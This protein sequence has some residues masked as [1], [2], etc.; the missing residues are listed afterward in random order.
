MFKSMKIGTRLGIGFLSIL[1]CASA[2]TYV[3]INRMGFL[4]EKTVS[5]YEHPYTTSNAISRVQLHIVKINRA[6]KDVLLAHNSGQ[7][8][9]KSQEISHLEKELY[10][11]H[12]ILK[13]SFLGDKAMLDKTYALIADWKKVRE[14]Q[15]ALALAGKKDEAEI[16]HRTKASLLVKDLEAVTEAIDDFADKKALSFMQNA[17]E[18]RKSAV[19]TV[20]SLLFFSI[21][22]SLVALLFLI[23]SVTI[24]LQAAV[25]ALKRVASGDLTANISDTEMRGDELGALMHAQ[26]TM[27]LSLAAIMRNLMDYA[28]KLSSSATEIGAATEEMSRG[29]DSQMNQVI[30]TSSGM[31]EMSASV[32]E[33][34]RNAKNTSETAV[35]A[36]KMAKDGS[37]KVKKTVAGIS[38]VNDS[39]RNLKVRSQKVGKVV[40]FISE[41]AAQT[42]ILALNAAI[43]AARAGEHGRG[44]DV[45]AEEIRRLAQ[46]TT[47][48]TA[49]IAATIEEIQIETRDAVNSMELSTAAAVEAGQ[50]IEDIVEGIVSTTDM[51]QLISSAAAQQAR[52][53]EE[54]SDSLQN[55][56]GVNKQTAQASREVAKA[57]QDLS[58][59]AEKLKEVTDKF[60]V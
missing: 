36:T 24:P 60:R 23:R 58:L 55:I 28:T 21:V 31:A 39:L 47:D 8:E 26:N 54:I 37:Q 3:A 11:E 49:E 6:M 34:S 25:V 27:I 41:I 5:L 42:N 16:I 4:A 45:V 1:I 56:S 30:K 20:Y 17:E 46:K 15:I 50:S 51:I 35:L 22:A 13:V 38:G 48:S 44:F 57:I 32:Q 14:Q 18:A 29:A 59:L 33:V 2:V 43:E 40:Q 10:K 12:E 9:E 53:G 7:I 52:T 19:A